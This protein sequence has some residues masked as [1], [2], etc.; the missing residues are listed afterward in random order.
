MAKTITTEGAVHTGSAKAIHVNM[1]TDTII[2]NMSPEGLRSIMR[3]L[4]GTDSNVAV[5]LDTLAAQYLAKTRPTSIPKLFESTSR[6]PKPMAALFELQ[7]R[8]RCLMGC[9][10]GFE[11]AATLCSVLRQTELLDWDEGS[12]EGEA[13]LDTLATIDGD[14]VQVVTAIQKELW[15]PSGARAMS[16]H[17][18]AIL[19]EMRNGLMA[20]REH[21]LSH[22]RE[23][24]FERGWSRLQNL[25]GVSSV[26]SPTANHD[27]VPTSNV[28][29]TIQLG[30]LVV[31]RMFMGL[32]QF[33]SPAWGTAS[34]SKINGHFRK[35]VD[36]GFTAYDMADHYGDA[37]VTFGQFRSSQPDASSIFCMTKWCVF[38]ATQ[39]SKE[40][41]TANI[42]ERV[43]NINAGSVEL[44]QFHWQ[45]VRHRSFYL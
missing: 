38:E 44:L 33:S 45:D 24:V 5:L 1:M 9:G 21:A 13:L 37:E 29:E 32:W 17:E 40:V 8:Y 36:A 34:R 15:Q 23:F 27:F 20:C 22:R 28:L 39:I 4:V 14:I 25:D 7:S 2:A 11:S 43:K 41:V 12:A 16:T 30:H 31:P 10:L 35:H 19:D 42:T 6:G 18:L 3:G 26:R